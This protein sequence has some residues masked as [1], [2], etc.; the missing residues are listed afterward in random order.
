MD[1]DELAAL[2]HAQGSLEE[3]ELGPKLQAPAPD[4]FGG[5]LASLRPPR[6]AG[7]GKNAKLVH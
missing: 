2:E 5:G 3:T 7:Q 1:L 4:R 6:L